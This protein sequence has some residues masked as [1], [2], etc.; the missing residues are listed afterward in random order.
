MDCKKEATRVHTLFIITLHY[1]IF[2]SKHCGSVARILMLARS[3]CFGLVMRILVFDIESLSA[4]FVKI[5]LHS[6]LLESKLYI[7][8]VNFGTF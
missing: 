7:F 4:Q 3:W 6:F 8:S 5:N 2:I 1:N